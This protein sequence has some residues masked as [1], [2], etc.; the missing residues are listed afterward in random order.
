MRMTKDDFCWTD[1][2]E[3]MVRKTLKFLEDREAAKVSMRELEEQV[4]SP[5]E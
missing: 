3:G 4:W 2:C 5:N 1:V